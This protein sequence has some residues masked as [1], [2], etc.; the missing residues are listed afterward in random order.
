[1]D[2]IQVYGIFNTMVED[3][4][5]GCSILTVGTLQSGSSQQSLAIQAIVQEQV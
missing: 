1:M 5:V 2:P 3:M 4:R